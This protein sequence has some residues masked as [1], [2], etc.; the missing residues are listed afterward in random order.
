MDLNRWHIIGQVQQCLFNAASAVYGLRSLIAKGSASKSAINVSGRDSNSHWATSAL[1]HSRSTDS[2]WPWVGLGRPHHRPPLTPPPSSPPWTPTAMT[3]ETTT[4]PITSIVRHLSTR[5]IRISSRSGE[6]L[7][8]STHRQT[9]GRA[10]RPFLQNRYFS[11][12]SVLLWVLVEFFAHRF[13]RSD[14]TSLLDGGEG[15]PRADIHVWTSAIIIPFTC[16]SIVLSNPGPGFCVRGRRKKK[17]RRESVENGCKYFPYQPRVLRNLA[18][19]HFAG[20]GVFL[21]V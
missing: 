19:W 12:H 6:S 14:K 17:F 21:L 7:C 15:G 11:N 2:G 9:R 5:L 3:A 20:R 10:G 16:F 4:L 8:Y 18:T 1:I 13:V